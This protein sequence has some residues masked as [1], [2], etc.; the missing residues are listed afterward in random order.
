MEHL[1]IPENY[2]SALSL[3]DT[4]VAI[5]TVKDF[6][7]QL[8]AERLNL[9]RVSAP[10][11][12][13]PESGLN[14]NLNGVERP[15]GFDIL[16]SGRDAEVVQSLAKWKRFALKKYGF[17]V[18][19]GLYTD[20]TAIRRDEITD[21]IHSIYVD[22]WDWEKIIR[23]E[24]RTLQTLE[25][26]VADVYRVLRKTEKYMAI[27]YDYIHEILPHD[28]FFIT[29]S[30]LE[31]LYPDKTPKDLNADIIVYYPVLDIALE[32]SS[33]GIRVDE[34][35]LAS[36]LKAAGCEDRA[37]L[38][39]QQAILNGELPFTIGGGIGQSRI[40]M[41]FLRKAHIGEVHCSIWP[42]Q[43]VATCESKGVHLL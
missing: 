29:T 24:D 2:E 22:Q 31:A 26:V 23:R 28:I 11:F 13:A 8:L 32:L 27:R 6:F 19:E 15:V 12:V 4:Q 5:K 37:E 21:N 10:L 14:D 3:H 7:Q 43:T 9:L 34:K 1:M 18:G 30:E 40:C 20:M 38:P 39:F 35:S 33:M 16:E 25:S 17:R 42:V 36:Q 41:F